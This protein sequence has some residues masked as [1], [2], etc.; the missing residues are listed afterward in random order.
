[1]ARYDTYGATD[2][3]VVEDLDQGFSGFNNKLRPD[4][5][6]SGVLSVSNN[7]RMDLNG[8]WQP[9]TGIEIFSTPFTPAVLKLY[10]ISDSLAFRLH[11]T[12]PDVA[13]TGDGVK[14]DYSRSGEVL[15]INFASAHG[16]TTGDIVNIDV[17]SDP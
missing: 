3:Q 13:T 5:L 17:P 14:T 16:I 2:D 1:M 9:R 11:D 8:E 7:G 12:L 15:T 4:Q 6:P 10:A